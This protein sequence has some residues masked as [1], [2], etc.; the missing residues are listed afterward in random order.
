LITLSGGATGRWHF[1]SQARRVIAIDAS[2]DNVSRFRNFCQQRNINNIKVICGNLMEHDIPLKGD[3]IWLYGLLQNITDQPIFLE[4]LK[5][6]A[7]GPDALFYIYYYNTNSLREFT[8]ETCRKIEDL[9]YVA[10][11]IPLL[12]LVA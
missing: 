5:S 8:V 12:E 11:S 7:P 3:F 2:E 6:M 10:S 9:F 4:K 1:V